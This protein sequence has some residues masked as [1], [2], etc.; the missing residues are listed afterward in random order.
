MELNIGSNLIRN[1]SG[2]L[3]V[4]GREQ[5]VLEIGDDGQLL[6]TMDLYDAGGKHIAKLRRNA[7]A[8]H[9]GDQFQVTTSPGNLTLTDSS[10]GVVLRARVLSPHNIEI[11]E[12]KFF[13]HNGHL[14]EITPDYF[15]IAGKVE[16]SGNVLDGNARAF[17]IG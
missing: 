13:T 10:N 16:M 2:V 14:L 17:R 4:A 12:G 6:L 9:E 5:I 7:W 11:T 8:F 1:T 15:R 3:N